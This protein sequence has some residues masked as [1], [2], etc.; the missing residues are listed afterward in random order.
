MNIAPRA[1]YIAIGHS[2]WGFFINLILKNREE[3]AQETSK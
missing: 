1:Q 3:V 2:F